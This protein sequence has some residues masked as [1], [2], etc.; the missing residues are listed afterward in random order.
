MANTVKLG[1]GNATRIDTAIET[2]ILDEHD[3]VLT[4]DT[5]EF[6]YIRDDKS[7]QFIRPRFRLFSSEDEA[8]TELND[9]VDTYA[10]Q[11]VGIMDD[12]GKYQMYIVQNGTSGFEVEP[13]INSDSVGLKWQ[14][15]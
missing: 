1:Y 6:V 9:E 14:S 7:K 11:M 10:G 8:V 13:I 4:D 5:S 2:G 15:F 12:D 3:L